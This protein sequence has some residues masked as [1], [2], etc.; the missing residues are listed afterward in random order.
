MPNAQ[1]LLCALTLLLFCPSA[2]AAQVT[3]VPE[4]TPPV[5]HVTDDEPPREVQAFWINVGPAIGGAGGGFHVSASMQ[6]NDHLWTGR[7]VSTEAI[8]GGDTLGD[9]GVLYG[10]STA[11]RFG[12]ASGAAGLGIV[13]GETTTIGLPVEIQAYFRP[14]PFAGLGVTLFGNV[15]PAQPFA[16]VAVALQLGDGP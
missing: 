2:L 12:L 14:L 9:L 16:G 8:L 6:I 7:F 10:R 4:G 3:A 11:G 15:N 1:R 5:E 13:Q